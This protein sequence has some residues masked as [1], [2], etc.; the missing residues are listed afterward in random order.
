MSVQT[1]TRTLPGKR[2]DRRA[3]RARR[4]REPRTDRLFMFCVYLL[5]A[6]LLAVVLLPLL[7][8]VASSFSSPEAVSGGRVLLWPVD[9]SLR[10]YH[11]VFANPQIIQG[12][13]N[14]LFYT[15]VGT[16]VS[17]TMTIAIAY[18]L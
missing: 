4:I 14:S 9:F 16:I 15:V 12:Y 6:V 17:V 8:I 1:E 11:A 5:L 2:A 18:P 13:L 10:G 3:A 7:Y